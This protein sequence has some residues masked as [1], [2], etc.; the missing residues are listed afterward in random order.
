MYRYAIHVIYNVCY[1]LHLQYAGHSNI[2]VPSALLAKRNHH[3]VYVVY[4][5]CLCAVFLVDTVYLEYINV[6][7]G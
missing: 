6:G 5:V 2:W 3:S 4:N 7:Y 1:A